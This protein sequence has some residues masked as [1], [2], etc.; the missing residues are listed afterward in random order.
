MNYKSM[1][2]VPIGTKMKIKKNQNIGK[3]VEI[4][5]FP[6]TFKIEFEDGTFGDFRTHEIEIIEED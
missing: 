2:I 5:N 6:T 1:N 4:F 3:L